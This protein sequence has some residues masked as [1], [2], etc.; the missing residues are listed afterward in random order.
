MSLHFQRTIETTKHWGSIQMK[1]K[2]IILVAATFTS[3]GAAY[4]AESGTTNGEWRTFGGDLSNTRYAPLD[5]INA[6]NFNDLELAWSFDTTAFGP[7]PE[8]NFQ[9]TPLMVDGVIYSTVGSRRAIVALDAATGELLWM[10]RENEGERA[11]ASP[12]R[13]SGRGLAYWNEGDDARI[14]YITQGYRLISLDAATGR[15]VSDFAENGVADLKLEADQEMDLING[16]IGL[17]ATP[18]VTSDVIIIG[19]AHLGGSQ[20]ASRRNEKGY[21]RGYDVR[22]GERL[23]IFHTIPL[24]SEYGADTW[25]GNSASYTGNTGIWTQI[26]VDEALGLVYLPVEQPT[27]DYY[28]GHRGGDGLFGESIVAVDLYTGERR[29]HYQLVHHGIWDFDIPSAPVIADI[30]VDGRKI[31]ALIQPSKQGWLYVLDRVTGEPVWP[32]EE[33]PVEQSDVPGEKS[34]PTQPFV[35][36]PPPFDV[37]GVSHDDLIDFTPELR[38]EAIDIISRYKIGP[39]FT[40]PV[41][42]RWEGPLATLMMPSTVGGANWAG[43]S[44]DPETNMFYIQSST[45]VTPL[46]LVPGGDQSDMDWIRGMITDP[47]VGGPPDNGRQVPT[48]QGLPITKPP[49][50]RITAFDMNTGNIAWQIPHGETPDEIRNHPSLEGIDIPRTGRP[51]RGGVLTTSTLLISGEHGFATTPFGRGAM[52]RAYDKNT[53]EEVGAVHMPA[54]QTGAPMTYM[55]DD[56]QYLVLAVGGASDRRYR[57]IQSNVEES[58]SGK[59]LAYRLPKKNSSE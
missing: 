25:E 55:L 14:I 45:A 41:V 34:S 6:T 10:H 31:Q 38:A 52:L 30:E 59:L 53:G 54:P 2:V 49:Y 35:T 43:G 9:S 27:N 40:P 13:L 50:G 20:P 7:T 42:S 8:Y 28:G 1:I 36:W 29:W 23:W 19:A 4:S 18:I 37:Q 46:G 17:H 3:Y 21:I 32:I 15:P 24:P 5:H 12:R 47:A 33:R 26:S 51:G 58:F 48:V 11:A 57:N 16:S 56:K 44:F 39:L 22:T